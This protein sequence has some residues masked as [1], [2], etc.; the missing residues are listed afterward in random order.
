MKKT[1]L[2]VLLATLWIA[3]S[4]FVRNQLLLKTAWEE[5]YAQ[6]GQVF[7]AA[8]LNGAIWGVWS[9]A[10]AMVIYAMARNGSLVRAT[11]LAWFIGF[12]LMWLVIGN[13]GVLPFSILPVA[14]PLSLL[15][16]FGAVLIVRRLR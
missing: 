6:M 5:H 13:L 8:P 1:V 7:P 2:P 3:T 10:Y 16:A 15:E 4:E 9:L 11:A 12:V 14:V